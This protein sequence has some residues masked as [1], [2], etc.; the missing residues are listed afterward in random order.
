MQKLRTLALVPALVLAAGS[1]LVAQ[2]AEV[3][4]EAEQEAALESANEWLTTV[5][6]GDYEASWALAAGAFQEAVT[7]DQWT[8]AVGQARG[9]YEPFG[10]RTLLG[11]QYTNELPNAPAG[12]YVIMQYRTAAKSG[13]VIETIACLKEGDAW[14]VSGYFVKPE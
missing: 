7:V 11:A 6:E 14:K 10:E 13:T 9:P 5:D 12:E 3:S 2:E 8:A 4:M 1:A